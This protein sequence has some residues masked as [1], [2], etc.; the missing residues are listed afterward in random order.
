MTKIYE[1]LENAG[2]EKSPGGAPSRG[3]LLVGGK[4]MPRP[5][6]DKLS[7]LYQRVSAQL[8]D[9]R[10]VVAFAGAQPGEEGSRI[11]IAFAQLVAAK[12]QLRTLL[13]ASSPTPAYN[14][15]G[16]SGLTAW[17]SAVRNGQG[18][19]GLI[20]TVGD[21]NLDVAVLASA[22]VVLPSVVASTGLKSIIGGLKQQ[23]DMILVD[24]PPFGASSD[25]ALMTRLV[26]GFV[27]VIEA[28]KTRHQAIRQYIGQIES[29]QGIVLGGILNRRRFYIPGF[30][31][32]KM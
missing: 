15:L 26:D 24:T 4:T 32:R 7:G 3:T 11:L 22:P 12:L 5:L 8:P 13:I 19:D 27:L 18:V 14:A 25:A 29:Q 16:V 9:G 28:G 1:A 2:K 31:Y 20:K 23:Y 17:E 30:I 21:S 10:G 6:E